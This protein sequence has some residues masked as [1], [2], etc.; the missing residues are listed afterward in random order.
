[1]STKDAIQLADD[2][3]VQ[4]ALT[5]LRVEGKSSTFLVLGFSTPN[6]VG[7]IGGGEGSMTE[8][9][10]HVPDDVERYILIRKDTKVELAKTVKFVF[11]A[12]TPS[13]VKPLR[14]AFLSTAY[15]HIV[16][17][18]KPFHVE[19]QISDK[20]EL[21]EE[22]ILK[23]IGLSSGTM[24]RERIASTSHSTSPSATATTTP[25][26]T[27]TATPT[28]S[29]SAP[30]PSSPSAST[31]ATATST[32]ARGRGTST[33]QQSNLAK[34][35]AATITITDDA[36]FKEALKKIRTD[37]DDTNW[38]YASY[39]GKCQLTLLGSGTGGPAEMVTKLEDENPGFGLI[40]VTEV[41]DPKARA[42]KFAYIVW[43]PDT[44]KPM[45]RAE[46]SANKGALES[47]FRPFHVELFIQ[48]QVDLTEKAVMD[49]VTAA[50][51]SKS[52][53]VS[54]GNISGDIA[55]AYFK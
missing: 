36:A 29:P 53:V 15:R 9:L 41:I 27:I 23:E 19:L 5:E 24:S 25:A 6:L 8:A 7:V 34:A 45:K 12:Y 33:S 47:L 4:K 14:K 11:I 38:L 51:G 46:L 52:H 1:M 21:T 44:I 35:G 30:A 42:T 13:T 37:K 49:S 32:P 3:S 26:A 55:R 48:K 39:S 31:T 50:S 28:T 2:G 17:V 43:Q 54:K 10:V 40:R 18:V 20:K 22:M 16:S